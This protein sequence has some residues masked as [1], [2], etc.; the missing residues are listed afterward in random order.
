MGVRVRKSITVAPGVRVNL[1]RVAGASL[2]IRVGPLGT[3][4]LS[5]RG[6]HWYGRTPV[7]GVSYDKRVWPPRKR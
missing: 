3:L 2:S 7:P 1:S 5:A 4:N 6:V